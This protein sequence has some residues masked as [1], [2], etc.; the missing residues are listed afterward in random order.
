MQTGK[1]LS[2]LWLL[3]WVPPLMVAWWLCPLFQKTA[4]EFETASPWWFFVVW[5][6]VR[7]LTPVLMIATTSQLVLRFSKAR[8]MSVLL[9]AVIA[10]MLPLVLGLYL[11]SECLERLR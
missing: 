6:Q 8:L 11:W 9:L 2:L 7:W 5:K 10:T 4:L 1:T 3:L